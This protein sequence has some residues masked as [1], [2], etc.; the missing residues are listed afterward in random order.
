[1]ICNSS[2]EIVVPIE[3]NCPQ[4]GRLLRA[5]DSAAGRQAKCP[6]CAGTV[7]IPGGVLDAEEFDDFGAPPPPAPHSSGGRRP[8]A[9]NEFGDAADSD[10]DFEAFFGPTQPRRSSY[11]GRQGSQPGT[12]AGGQ[13]PCP[14]CG[15]MIQAR[16]ARCRYCGE[17]LHGGP[18]RG[19][20]R[21]PPRSGDDG[22][23]L[24]I[25]SLV[26]GI[27]SLLLCVS[28]ITAPLAIIFGVMHQGKARENGLMPSGQA[29][30]GITCGIIA[31]AL[32]GL[33]VLMIAV[34]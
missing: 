27:I 12:A 6:E 29:T 15:E 21:L 33:V 10:D 26:L 14:V 25:A 24:A 5:P 1:V 3:V 31:L 34:G 20:R 28:P 22:E 18:S 16:A 4:C 7:P 9:R 23:G 2:G 19:G 11:G 32:L 13:K 8:A 17:D 30:A